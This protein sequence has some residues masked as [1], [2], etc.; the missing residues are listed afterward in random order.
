MNVD[1]EKELQKKAIERGKHEGLDKD[2]KYLD[3]SYAYYGKFLE[4]CMYKLSY[5]ECYQCKLPYFGGLKDCENNNEGGN[6]ENK[7]QEFDKKDLVCASCSAVAI[8][9]GILNC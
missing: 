1:Y 3:K 5:Y 8:G 6:E 4:F 2:K 7:Q 9:E